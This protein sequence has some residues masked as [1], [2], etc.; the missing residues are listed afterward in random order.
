[1]LDHA[2][3]TATDRYLGA[4]LRPEDLARLDSAFLRGSAE[5]SEGLGVAAD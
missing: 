1:M 3:L 4:K 5:P 2:K